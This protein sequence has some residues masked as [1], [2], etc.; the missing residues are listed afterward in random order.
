[1]HF[2]GAA[3]NLIKFLMFN[4][5]KEIFLPGYNTMACWNE[6]ND[7]YVKL[8]I[9]LDVLSKC[10]C[11]N[12]IVP[13]N[14][15]QSAMRFSHHFPFHASNSPMPF[16]KFHFYCSIAETFSVLQKT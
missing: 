12:K 15:K 7:V 13:F 5:V 6:K 9:K 2:N 11:S 10:L 14:E 4:V 3:V 16:K 8:F 1:M